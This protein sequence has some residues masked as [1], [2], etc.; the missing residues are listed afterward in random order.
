MSHQPLFNPA[1][2][3]QQPPSNPQS[4][5]TP[6]SPPRRPSVS[7]STASVRSAS[8]SRRPSGAQHHRARLNPTSEDPSLPDAVEDFLAIFSQDVLAREPYLRGYVRALLSRW[9]RWTARGRAAAV[10]FEAAC[11][12]GARHL[13]Q[14]GVH[15]SPATSA[16]DAALARALAGIV[17]DAVEPVMAAEHDGPVREKAVGIV[18]DEF[19]ARA[20]SP[21]VAGP[22]AR[23]A[24]KRQSGYIPRNAEKEGG[25]AAV[26]ET[27]AAAAAAAAPAAA[28]RAGESWG[29]TNS[30][31]GIRGKRT[32]VDP[33]HP[34]DLLFPPESRAPRL[35]HPSTSPPAA[36]GPPF[37]LF[38]ASMDE[39]PPVVPP[40]RTRT[41]PSPTSFLPPTFRSTR[42]PSERSLASSENDWTPVGPT[43]HSLRDTIID[44]GDGAWSPPFRDRSPTG[45]S[46]TSSS[47]PPSPSP[48][49]TPLH[50]ADVTATLR[51]EPTPAPPLTGRIERWRSALPPPNPQ[52]AASTA[53]LLNQLL[54]EC[55]SYIGALGGEKE[56]MRDRG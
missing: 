39:P 6:S 19:L 31:R 3:Q 17:V 40:R 35:A 26:D 24:K 50:F 55:E 54:D 49:L 7:S 15:P 53:L 46:T 36:A 14:I 43:D 52:A 37:D 44:S 9:G 25:E 16:V 10:C 18:A 20:A 33:S 23:R 1:A 32:A 38:H 42:R 21:T 12:G 2:W 29:R 4:V 45:E 51:I 8:R 28:T 22:A 48:S 47:P 5:S 13:E 41:E 56:I 30:A 34:P 11:I 27:E